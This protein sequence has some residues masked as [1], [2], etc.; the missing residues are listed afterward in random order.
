MSASI[1]LAVALLTGAGASGRGG[2][3]TDAMPETRKHR[4]Q[5]R[6]QIDQAIFAALGEPVLPN[7]PGPA[8]AS[9]PGASESR[10]PVTGATPFTTGGAL[11]SFTFHAQPTAPK[12]E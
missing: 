2:A 11:G 9:A 6:D 5:A 4:V 8:E 3:Y 1:A 7:Q 12:K 10:S